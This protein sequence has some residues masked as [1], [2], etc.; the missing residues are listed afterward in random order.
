MPSSCARS[1]RASRTACRMPFAARLEPSVGTRIL[2][3]RFDVA[4]A[5]A[6]LVFELA[7]RG[8]EG[9]AHCNPH[10]LVVLAVDRDFAARHLQVDAHAEL[11]SLMSYALDDD[12]AAHEAGLEVLQPL[13][14]LANRL[15]QLGGLRDVAE[16]DL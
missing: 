6:H 12:A 1:A 13:G 8:V 2:R 11:R 14:A 7:A 9:V 4:T 5:Q 3:M 10:V 16:R 15:V